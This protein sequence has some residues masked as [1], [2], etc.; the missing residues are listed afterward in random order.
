MVCKNLKLPLGNFV[1][2]NIS[3]NPAV[4]IRRLIF[5]IFPFLVVAVPSMD[6]DARPR[7][8]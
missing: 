3:Q 5:L 8:P 2:A 4:E 7:L 1:N 6:K